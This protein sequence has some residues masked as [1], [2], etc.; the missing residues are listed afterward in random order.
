MPFDDGQKVV[1]TAGTRVPVSTT[2]TKCSFLTLIALTSNTLQ[3]NVGDVGVVA[4]TGST[5]RGVPLLPGDSVTLYHVDL[6]T[7]Y[8]D[9]RADGEGVTYLWG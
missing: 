8:I 7:T 6:S 4:A 3:V 2:A 1:T 5:Q 9:S